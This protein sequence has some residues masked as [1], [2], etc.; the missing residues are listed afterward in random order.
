M[1]PEQIAQQLYGLIVKISAEN[2]I[3]M[4]EKMAELTSVIEQIQAGATPPATP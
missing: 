2:T 3:G 1:T 4:E